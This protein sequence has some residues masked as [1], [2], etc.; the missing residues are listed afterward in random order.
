MYRSLRQPLLRYQPWKER[1]CKSNYC[2]SRKYSPMSINGITV[3]HN[4]RD[5][6][7]SYS[8]WHTVL[9][10]EQGF[11][12]QA[13]SYNF[14]LHVYSNM[15]SLSQLPVSGVQNTVHGFQR[16][17]VD[18]KRVTSQCLCPSATVHTVNFTTKVET[19]GSWLLCK[20]GWQIT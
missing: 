2:K 11:I 9:Y 17:L 4:K 10:T 13:T 7:F 8:N 6:I 3:R 12:F 5:L 20:G 18:V 15:L 14:S 19:C 1:N 16:I